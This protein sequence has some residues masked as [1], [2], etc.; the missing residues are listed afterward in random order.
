[1]SL[2]T[3]LKILFLVFKALN[4]LAPAYICDLL[5]PN[6][7]GDDKLPKNHLFY[8]NFLLLLC[9]ALLL[10]CIEYTMRYPRYLSS[11]SAAANPVA[12]MQQQMSSNFTFLYVN[13][14]ILCCAF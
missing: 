12:K 9:S 10:L 8:T 14:Y 1:M 3:H 6:E 5:T 13:M 4:G 11:K 2:R 7:H